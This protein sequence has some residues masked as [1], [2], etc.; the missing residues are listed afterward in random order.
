MSGRVNVEELRKAYPMTDE[1][2]VAENFDINQCLDEIVR[3]R[4]RI[5]HIEQQALFGPDKQEPK[6]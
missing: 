1:L 2:E 6:P 4:R 5:E 3:L